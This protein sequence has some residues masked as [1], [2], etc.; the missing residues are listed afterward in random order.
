[1]SLNSAR[2]AT[3]DINFR[4]QKHFRSQLISS[5]LELGKAA[6]PSAKKRVAYLSIE[7]ASIPL[8]KHQLVKMKSRRHCVACKGLRHSDRPQKRRALSKII[9]N[10]GRSTEN[11]STSFRC[12]QCDV[13]LCSNRNCFAVFH[14]K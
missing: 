10:A 1:L 11:R 9:G 6:L 8:E 4:S 12:K 3:P 2:E 7:A 5:L 13:W 14:N